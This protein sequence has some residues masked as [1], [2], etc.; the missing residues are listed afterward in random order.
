MA[1]AGGDKIVYRQFGRH[2]DS[3]CIKENG[4]KK[5]GG[6]NLATGSLSGSNRG[7]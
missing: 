6:A 2:N 7:A 1:L 3:D 4:G 5:N